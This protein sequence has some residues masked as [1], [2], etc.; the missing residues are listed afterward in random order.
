MQWTGPAV[1]RLVNFKPVGAVP[2]MGRRSAIPLGLVRMT[3]AP[4]IPYARRAVTPVNRPRVVTFWLLSC[5]AGLLSNA[6]PAYFILCLL[7]IPAGTAVRPMFEV[8]M[9]L[10]GTL[11]GLAVG[12]PLAIICLVAG[13]R[14]W[15]GWALG[16]FAV[17]V[18][19]SPWFVSWALWDWVVARQDFIMEP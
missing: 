19:C 6:I 1:E 13:R 11:G 9:I 10:L 18:S 14:W 15:V 3:D 16:L 5:A 2:A 4:T 8:G 17:I 12:L 7:K